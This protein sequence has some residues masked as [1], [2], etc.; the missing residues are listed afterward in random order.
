MKMS[1]EHYN[2]INSILLL[3]I[4]EGFYIYGV[5]ME[6]IEYPGL[7]YTYPYLLLLTLS[8]VKMIIQKNT[9]KGMDIMWYFNYMWIFELENM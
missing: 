8:G 5:A 6:L 4:V 7:L 3:I 2:I 1:K 9:W